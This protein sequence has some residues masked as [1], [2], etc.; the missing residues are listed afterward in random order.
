MPFTLSPDATRWDELRTGAEG[1][2][3][4]D[5]ARRTRATE[6][7]MLVVPV[8]AF[9]A[10]VIVADQDAEAEELER[11][12]ADFQDILGSETR[13]RTIIGEELDEIVE[14]FGDDRRDRRV[15]CPGGPGVRARGEEA[16]QGVAEAERA[17]HLP[18]HRDHRDR[19]QLP[20]RPRL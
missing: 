4:S 13:Q 3:W 5:A 17:G 19:V 11:K 8:S 14:R 16:G 7:I 2:R 1:E 12:I 20:R 10:S 15:A 18:R 9:G 6:Y